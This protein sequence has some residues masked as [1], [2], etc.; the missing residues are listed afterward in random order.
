VP[1]DQFNQN[2]R[3]DIDDRIRRKM[4][5]IEDRL[6]SHE[7]RRQY[8][9][10]HRRQHSTASGILFGGVIVLLGLVLLLDNMGIVRFHDVWRYWPVLLIIWGA[11]R[12]LS[13][14][15][16]AGYVWGGGVALVGALFLLDNLEI[17]YFN[18]DLIWP[19]IIIAFG[20]SMLL[21]AVDRK[22]Y[23]D[24]VPASGEP[25]MNVVAVF[26]GSKRTLDSQDFRGGEVVAVF[27]GVRLDLRRATIAAEKAVIDIN[28]IFGGVEIRIPENWNVVM[29]GAGIFGGFDDK[30]I[31]PKPDPNTKT[32]ELILTGAAVFGGLSVTN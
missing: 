6:R 25:V 3:D 2:L 10:E 23:L 29:K 17:I 20:L 16:L 14:Q 11:S 8:Q 12:I 31:H 32:P 18:F 13:S 19:M 24:G 4:S 28:A 5:R 30:T 15:S 7:Q 22:R 9:R 26:S 27:G 1:D 21:R